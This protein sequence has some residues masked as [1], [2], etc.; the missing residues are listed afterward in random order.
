MS[1]NF[2]NTG[3]SLSTQWD[4][5]S[6][7]ISSTKV[8]NRPIRDTLGVSAA[9]IARAQ[10]YVNSPDKPTLATPAPDAEHANM[11]KPMDDLLKFYTGDVFAAVESAFEWQVNEFSKD[12]EAELDKLSDDE[13]EDIAAA[14]G[15][16]KKTIKSMIRYGAFHPKSSLASLIKQYSGPI[17]DAAAKKGGQGPRDVTTAVTDASIG[18]T[19]KAV[20]KSALMDS[21]LSTEEQ[22]LINAA[23]ENPALISS[24][25]K[26]LQA[27]LM[28]MKIIA[29]AA[30]QERYGVPD[31]WRPPIDPAAF[32]KSV[33]ESVETKVGDAFY[34][35]LQDGKL[36]QSDYNTIRT[37]FYLGS[38]SSPKADSLKV[39]LEKIV[40][41][42]QGPIF[43]KKGIPS[44]F[45]LEIDK[46][47][48]KAILTGKFYNL[49]TTKINEYNPPLSAEDKAL[50]IAALGSLEKAKQIP[51]ALK[52]IFTSIVS[53]SIDKVSKL[54]GLPEGWLPE[55][56]M[57][58]KA[59]ELSQSIGMKLMS[60]A[61]QMADEMMK[62]CVALCTK[63]NLANFSPDTQG[64]LLNY[65]KAVNRALSSLRETMF[66][67]QVTQ[68]DLSTL[69]S[70][71][72]QDAALDQI[73]KRKE[74]LEEVKE[75]QQKM[76][77]MGILNIIMMVIFGALLYAL[78]GVPAAPMIFAALLINT[79]VQSEGKMSK[80]DLLGDFAKTMGAIGE[81]IGG[82]AMGKAFIVIA[83]YV[84]Y[85]TAPEVFVLDLMFGKGAMISSTLTALGFSKEVAGYITMAVQIA[86]AILV[87]AVMAGL[88]G[89]VGA[90]LAIM[91]IAAQITAL[92]GGVATALATKIGS[93]IGQ[94]TEIALQALITS[95]EKFV[96][97]S[98]S[99]LKDFAEL[100]LKLL[101]KMLE[102]VQRFTVNALRNEA[103]LATATE[104]MDKAEKTMEQTKT[105][106]QTASN[107]F[108]S[109][110]NA[111]QKITDQIEDTVNILANASDDAAKY[112]EEFG[113]NIKKFLVDSKNDLDEALKNL[114]KGMDEVLKLKK[115][116][117]ESES[118]LDDL[119]REL[120]N[121]TDD[122]VY[123]NKTTPTTKMNEINDK[124]RNVKDGITRSKEAIATA[125]KTVKEAKEALIEVQSEIGTEFDKH[126]KLLKDVYKP[127]DNITINPYKNEALAEAMDM[128]VE[129][130]AHYV[131]DFENVMEKNLLS[132]LAIAA[133]EIAEK[134]MQAAMHEVIRPIRK[135][136][137]TTEIA[138]KGAETYGNV[139]NSILRGLIAQLRA[140]LDEYMIG[141]QAAIKIVQ[142]LMNKLLESVQQLAQY[143]GTI[144]DMIVSN[145]A[146]QSR[147]M[148][149]LA[150]SM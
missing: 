27:K 51:P 138:L 66:A 144:V 146:K 120:S 23:N 4:K 39:I 124:I 18:I 30:V 52:E 26:A 80:M 67:A 75:K 109:V 36:S 56:S 21:G 72:A 20:F 28:Q 141:I 133:L 119:T 105:V 107:R 87:I 130:M 137:E 94:A 89:G 81:L 118:Y 95:L 112:A 68:S 114:D 29:F 150:R 46:E 102:K 127:P 55:T 37:L 24:L 59:G 91:Q 143:I 32:M 110:K 40:A 48:Y 16:P 49:A 100:A 78:L 13:L 65:L 34:K 12:T 99:V 115:E 142:M 108:E 54:Y 44:N 85:A 50:L 77:N 116:L 92:T 10:T 6:P 135:F 1:D 71:I 61:V 7:V 140:A 97:E 136:T 9:I 53:A 83:N 17:H 126:M 25:P 121:A 131:S 42:A 11:E 62:S 8:R 132:N 149:A 148:A 128:W 15:K 57:L 96:L 45:N 38:S 19:Y 129:A 43:R 147:A 64:K 113:D 69:F 103:H 33:A 88:T 104:V 123:A 134:T 73:K 35:M 122:A 3:S 14:M 82:E 117:L 101:Q 74:Q 145:Y 90:Q 5:G 139:K 111:V 63:E 31:T 86:F 58:C 70:R 98:Q 93:L 76:E 79:M 60:G 41:D 106:A 2:I 84:V 22:A 125:E 47:I